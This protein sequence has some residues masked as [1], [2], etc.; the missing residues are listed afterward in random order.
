MKTLLCLALL[1]PL[2]TVPEPGTKVVIG[3]IK[4][5]RGEKAEFRLVAVDPL[6]S[7][8][9]VLAER[10]TGPGP[11]RFVFP[12]PV[13]KPNVLLLSATHAT[14]IVRQG[15]RIKP[16]PLV[17]QTIR[18]VDE[19]GAPVGNARVDY[20]AGWPVLLSGPDGLLHLKS[21]TTSCVRGPVP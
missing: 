7:H 13:V 9:E 6:H 16:K 12:R 20:T 15:D 2:A 5:P 14:E 17:G 3:E 10:T 4:L 18:V 1:L 8:P 19:K 11:F 21:C